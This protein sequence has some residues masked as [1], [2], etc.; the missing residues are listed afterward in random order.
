MVVVE[1]DYKEFEEVFKEPKEKTIDIL[2]KIG[3][4]AEIDP[5][6]GKIFAEI[7]P[8]RP[9]WYSVIGLGRAV[10]AF[11]KKEVKKY[12]VK[13]GEYKIV[14]DKKVSRIRPY[15]VG[16][17][18]KGLK[19]GDKEI[20]D[21][22]LLQEKLLFTLGRMVK[23]FGIGF[24]PLEKINF[25]LKYTT[26]KPSE[27]RF[28][29]LN[30]PHEADV[31]E[32]LENHPKG[33]AYGHII[34]GAKEYPV[35]LDASGKIMALIPII[36]SNETGKVEEGTQGV[37][38][39]VTGM[40]EVGINQ[41]LNIIV[42]HLIDLGGEA[43]SVDV[44]YEKKT[45]TTPNL[46]Y[47]EAS[48]KERE[49][50][51]VLGVE[52]KAEEIADALVKMGYYSDGKKCYIQPYRADI[53]STIDIIE[54]IAI[55]YGYENFEPTIPDFFSAGKK[56]AKKREIDDIMQ[57]LGFIE[58]VT[59]ILTSD[60]DLAQFGATGIRVLNPKTKEYTTVRSTMLSSM[61]GV[62]ERN[63]MAG[64]P[65]LLYE[66]GTIVEDDKEKQMLCLALVDKKME[67]ERAR[68]Y[69]QM[70]FKELGKNFKLESKDYGFLESPFSMDVVADGRRIGRG[71]KLSEEIRKQKKLE[72]EIFIYE[73]EI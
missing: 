4:P 17:V 61:L 12:Q 52:L 56:N 41:A 40:D 69:L 51:K 39:E 73:I 22:V 30:Y 8:N 11:T 36:N 35:Y 13:K 9:D 50:K 18:V 62:I 48:V 16:A 34:A 20:R 70:I 7:T 21:L 49:V 3:A 55:A 2:N 60:D 28:H 54:D 1:F 63:K 68:G 32:I 72:N 27:I 33:Q 15:T 23:R 14:V 24:Y 67:F 45:I 25:P 10:R 57:R 71:G 5:E 37:F 58:V 6:T 29:P 19:L 64:L 53:I 42:C 26:M 66:V 43:Y 31:K 46:E 47:S 38:V 65:Q 59:T 44:V